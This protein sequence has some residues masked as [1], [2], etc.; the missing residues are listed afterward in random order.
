MATVWSPDGRWLAL[1]IQSM[2]AS[3][4][5]PQVILSLPAAGGRPDT[6]YPRA[7]AAGVTR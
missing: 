6:V 7:E 4:T 3:L 5:D 1:G 2:G